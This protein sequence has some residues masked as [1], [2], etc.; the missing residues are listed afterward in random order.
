MSDQRMYDILG[1]FQNLD[2]KLTPVKETAK[3]PVYENVEARGS[4][5]EAVKSL[6]EKYQGFKKT[7]AAIKKGGSAED[8]E[9]VAAAIGRKKYGKKKFQKAAAAGKKLG[10]AAK[11]D[12]I[13]LDKDGNK[14][15]PMKQAAKDAKKKSVK[16]GEY[17]PAAPDAEAIAKRKRLQALKD[18]AE[19]ERSEKVAIINHMCAQLRAKPTVALHKKMMLRKMI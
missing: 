7:V 11:P 15:E 1:K 12:Y 13:D 9:A 8:P 17:E 5:T 3:D 6:E 10:E 19:D 2:P 18:K 14:T 4:I 16:E